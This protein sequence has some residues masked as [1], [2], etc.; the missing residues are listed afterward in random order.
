MHVLQGPG[1]VLGA[2]WLESRPLLLATFSPWA[3]CFSPSTN[4]QSLSPPSSSIAYSLLSASSEQDNP[5]TSGCRLVRLRARGE[6]WGP[7]PRCGA[8]GST[9]PS[10]WT[11]Q[12]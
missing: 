11:L 5:S 2:G 4:S 6:G 1:V 12:Q 3:C 7:G 9:P 10:L 8:H